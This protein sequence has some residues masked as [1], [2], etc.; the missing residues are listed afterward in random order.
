MSK[1][2]VSAGREEMSHSG[3]VRPPAKRVEVQ[4]SREFK[5]LHLRWWQIGSKLSGD[6]RLAEC[7]GTELSD[8]SQRRADSVLDEANFSRYT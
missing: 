7:V 2:P 3:L 8:P 5:S 6:S 1:L 4:T